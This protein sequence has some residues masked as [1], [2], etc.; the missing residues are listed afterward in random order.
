[1]GVHSFR[2][3]QEQEKR[4]RAAGVV[5]GRRAKEFLEAEARRLSV[6][7]TMRLVAHYSR[8]PRVPTLR[9]LREMREKA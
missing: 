1:M 3:S 5:P 2:L 7:E 8:K 6:E 4:L 9:I